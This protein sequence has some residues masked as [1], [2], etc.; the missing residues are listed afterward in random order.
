MVCHWVVFVSPTKQMMCFERLA[1]LSASELIPP[2]LDLCRR[3]ARLPRLQ[4]EEG[5]KLN[6]TQMNSREGRGGEGRGQQAKPR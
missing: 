2:N 3:S 4:Q 1:S 6:E 5:T